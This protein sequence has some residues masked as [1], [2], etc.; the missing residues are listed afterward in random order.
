MVVSVDLRFYYSYVIVDKSLL[1]LKIDLEWRDGQPP[2]E[3]VDIVR[4]IED[5]G[6][7]Y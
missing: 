5:A 4:K 6:Q 2:F 3:T 7:I 1:F